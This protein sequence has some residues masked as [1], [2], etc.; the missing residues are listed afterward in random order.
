[1]IFA[2]VCVQFVQSQMGVGGQ[3]TRHARRLYVGGI[4]HDATEA[5]IAG[6]FNDIIS[7]VRCLPGWCCGS[8]SC[9][10]FEQALGKPGDM[11]VMTV[12]I[13]HERCFAFVELKTI[14][15]TTACMQVSLVAL[16]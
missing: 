14:E 8:L 13:N 2:C 7:R 6:Y 1:M 9:C 16:A 5:E 4:G 3:Q 11:P 15:L 12:Y 10:C